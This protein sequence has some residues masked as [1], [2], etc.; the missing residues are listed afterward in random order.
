VPGEDGSYRWRFDPLHRT[1]A[2]MAFDL[3]RF[4]TFL[5]AI[6]CP[7]LMVWG[8]RSPMRP[9]DVAE[10]LAL[11]SDLTEFVLPGAA[12]NLHHERPEE[13]SAVL[14]G[15]FEGTRV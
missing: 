14:L 1:T 13:L 5:Q 8:E 10:R 9:P 6:R 12:H 11:L 15:F 2:P 7:T 4:R 3:A